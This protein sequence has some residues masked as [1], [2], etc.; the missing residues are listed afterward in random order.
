MRWVLCMGS[1][2]FLAPY[3]FIRAVCNELR[4]LALNNMFI[5]DRCLATDTALL[6]DKSPATICF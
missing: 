6:E 5:A 4:R 3:C 2:F 1:W